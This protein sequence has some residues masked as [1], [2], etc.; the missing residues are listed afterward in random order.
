MKTIERYIVS[1][2][3]TAILLCWLVL[4][5]VLSIGLLVKVT[6]L[7]AKGMP[8]GVI[9][10]Y[11]LT[12]IPQTIGFTIPLSVLIG[13]L[14]VFGRLS[15]DSEIAA[16][17]AC[18]I[19][20]L[21]VMLWPLL[22]AG[23][24]SLICLQIHNEIAPRSEEAR[25]QLALNATSNMGLDLMEPGTFNDGPNQMKIW[26]ASRDGEWLSDLRIYDK[27]KSGKDREIRATRARV[28]RQG[29]NLRL[30]L[31]KATIDPMD[32]EHPGAA[33]ADRFSH[34]VPDAFKA[35]RR[36]Q[37]VRTSGSRELRQLL[38]VAEKLHADT[39]QAAAMVRSCPDCSQ[40]TSK[41]KSACRNPVH[42]MARI[43]QQSPGLYDPTLVKRLK[44]T[45]QECRARGCA[46]PSHARILLAANAYAR[47]QGLPSEIRVELH[48][49]LALA[50]APF[51]FA[52]IGIP[53]GI[54]SHR[55]E[56]TAGVAIGLGIALLYYV[57][58]ILA[59][60]LKRTPALHPELLVW[61]PAAICVALAVW[62]I[63]KNQ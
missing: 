61:L 33:H 46:D 9:G 49:R 60:A 35:A 56:S 36:T 16:M 43:L 7:I 54:R 39:S 62:L 57:V 34:E 1:S 53:L 25:L 5:F 21:R 8:V 44:T 11:F 48:K 20:L 6:S 47:L 41:G 14:L 19:N 13:A 52:L 38:P 18:G 32:D 59:E 30:D 17:R 15:T 23:G 22:L 40:R 55:R 51:C 28:N 12:G 10:E 50:C 26:F 63:P 2:F 4:T 29:D 24:L 42:E 31:Y 27:T 3:L 37:K 58:M 45:C